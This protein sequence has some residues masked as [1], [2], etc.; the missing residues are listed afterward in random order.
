MTK[1]IYAPSLAL[2]TD[3]YQITMAQGY[4]QCQMHDR[5]AVFH[6]FFRN[7]PFGGQYAVAAG[8]GP[9]VEWLSRFQV[10]RE[11]VDYLRTLRG[12][13]SK[14]LFSDEFLDAISG[15]RLSVDIDAM[16]EGTIAFAHQPL[17]R[18]TG[19]LWQCQWIESALLNIINFQTLIATKAARVCDAAEGESVLEFGLRRA[20][21]IDGAISA[22]RAAFI[23]GCDATSNVLAGRLLGIPVRGTHSHS[24]VLSFDDELSAFEAYANAMPNN[25]V[26]LVDT[27]D[28]IDGVRNAI[29]V[30]RSL[31]DSGHKMV[32]IRVDSGDLAALS[33]EARKLLDE[34]G[35]SD[36]VI[37]A[38]ND[39]DEHAIM[40]L[41]Q[42]GSKIAVWGVG[43]KLVTAFDQPALG[44]V[45]K[46]GAVQD[47]A[48]DWQPRIKLSDLPVKTS[49]PG[50]QQV[51]RY[52]RDGQMVGDILYSE[53]IGPPETP[54]AMTFDGESIVLS[55]DNSC[56]HEDLLQR[57]MSDG[58]PTGNP[59]ALE[60][61]QAH[62]KQQRQKLP[63]HTRTIQHPEAYPVGLETRLA[64]Q[65]HGMIAASH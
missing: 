22:S 65:K 13:D 52:T 40:D 29:R 46:L 63:P 38:S 11:D 31:R 20:Q 21:G 6:L 42:H 7:C 30:G 27:Y 2:L 18:I 37:V 36:A 14:A 58:N 24:W 60:Q 55:S 33:I 45:C 32:G 48:G 61:I 34:A 35:F 17:L 64:E 49:T 12:N 4:W 57:V 39:L 9:A 26:F 16:P 23:G 41:K 59:P 56:E 5:R 28:T 62:A 1:A 51:R 15:M 8:L 44:G 19:P 47:A 25:G 3:L 53:L 50:I 10:Q 43:T 54:S